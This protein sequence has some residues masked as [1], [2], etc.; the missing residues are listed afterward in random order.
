MGFPCFECGWDEQVF[1]RLGA[2]IGKLLYNQETEGDSV[3]KVVID[4]EVD[5]HKPKIRMQLQD[6]GMS[7]SIT[8]IQKPI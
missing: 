6:S 1:Q 2:K 8:T 4:Q 7:L 3:D 5:P